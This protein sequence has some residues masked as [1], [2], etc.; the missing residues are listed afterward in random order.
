MAVTLEK[1]PGVCAYFPQPPAV[2]LEST[3]GKGRI[4][5]TQLYTPDFLAV[6]DTEIVVIETR[7]ERRLF[8]QML[9][10]PHQF[11]RDPDGKWHFSPAEKYF[12]SLGFRYEL[13]TTASLP[14]KLVENERFLEDYISEDCPPLTDEEAAAIARFI[15]DRRFAPLHVLL[16]QGFGSDQIFKAIADS[17]V[18]VDLTA[19]LLA[20]TDDVYVYAD[21]ATQTAHQL[22]ARSA[23]EPALPIP[24]SM[25]LRTGSQ[26]TF[27]GRKYTVLLVGEREVMLED[28]NGIPTPMDVGVISRMHDLKM[29]E[30]DGVKKHADMRQLADCSP[31][32]L[33]R[34]VERLNAARSGESSSFAARSIS[35]FVTQIAHAAND[36]EALIA[37]V[38]NRR[39]SGNRK[40]KVSVL[41]EEIIAKAISERYNI[42]EQTTKKGAYHRYLKLCEDKKESSGQDLRPISYPTFCRHCEQQ[43]KTEARRGRR[44][45]YQEAQIYQAIENTYPV[46][47]VRPHEVLYVDHTI[48]NLATVSP[49]GVPLG[50]PTLTIG[51]DGNTT[52]PRALVLSYDPASTR[53]VLLLLR[54]YVRRHSR[55]PRVIVVDNGREFHSKELAHFCSLYGIDLR[56]RGAGMPRGGAMIERLLGA[57]EDEALS[58]MSGNTRAMKKDTRLITKSVD[59]FRRAEWTLFAA[60]QAIQEYLFDVRPNRVHP[61]LGETPNAYEQR[62]LNETGHREHRLFRLDENL[63][64]MTSPHARRPF[65]LVDRQRGVWVDGIWYRHPAMA[66]VKRRE[67]VEVRVEP[68]NASVVYVLIK[69]RWVAAVGRS[70]RWLV[71]RTRREVEISLREESRLSKS[72]AN[73][74][75]ISA[76]SRKHKEKLWSPVNFD[77]RLAEQAKEMAYLYSGLNMTN[78]MPLPKEL[79]DLQAE[80]DRGISVPAIASDS[81][82]PAVLP[83]PS[84]PV[85]VATCGAAST[86]AELA[87]PSVPVNDTR[88]AGAVNGMP[89]YY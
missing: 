40:R 68:W 27:D 74:G 3:D 85:E 17:V 9:K 60:Y 41:N 52:H 28:E 29:L 70:A 2:N 84:W 33:A 63:M 55:L 53:T 12:S 13:R 71:G 61:A 5:T 38:D 64:L 65:H 44:A 4:T 56:F 82:R 6:R 73:K 80:A 7:V 24:G 76:N 30:A 37:L 57:A 77:P 10:S 67:K 81:A 58:E 59:P 87:E 8:D 32:E 14:G 39:E 18:T 69:N 43:S 48:A 15:Q 49:H 78:A 46:H 20:A 22:V 51:V 72:A 47:G 21:E 11:S 31:G 45:A 88:F 19:T 34:A 83:P 25:L 62:R 1:D 35:R 86:P 42:P 54:D 16:E 23:R 26:L 50:K 79:A 66:E 36:L 75:T 89:G